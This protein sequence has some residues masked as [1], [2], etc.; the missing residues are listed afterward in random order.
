M[1]FCTV[2]NCMDGRVQLPV[3]Q[4]LQNRFNCEYVDVIS[5]PGPNRILAE[6]TDSTL[7]ASILSRL[8]ISVDKHQSRQIAVVGHHDC[9]GNPVSK[10]TQL[11]HLHKAVQFIARR[12][13][14]HTVI[15]LWV[16][17]NW[18]VEEVC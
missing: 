17:E 16:D 13:P 18:R 5:E 6:Q 8:T 14:E 4:Y 7:I 3:I 1:R 15:G 11:E 10:E 12:Y 9:A 2:I